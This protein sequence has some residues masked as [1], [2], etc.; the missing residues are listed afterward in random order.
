[1]TERVFES[2]YILLVQIINKIIVVVCVVT[3]F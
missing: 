2:R 3:F 1:M